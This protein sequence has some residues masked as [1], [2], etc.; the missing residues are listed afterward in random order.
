MFQIYR[1]IIFIMV[2]FA[3]LDIVCSHLYLDTYEYKNLTQLKLIDL[4]MKLF[5]Y[6]I[7]PIVICIYH[8][9]QQI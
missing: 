4:N 7:L 9:N 6:N 3:M 2:I 5:Q 1:I 8:I